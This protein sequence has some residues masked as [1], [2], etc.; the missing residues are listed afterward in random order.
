MIQF[1]WNIRS[2]CHTV[3]VETT[4][5]CTCIKLVLFYDLIVYIIILFSHD[6]KR[7]EN[8]LFFMKIGLKFQTT[9]EKPRVNTWYVVAMEP[10]PHHVH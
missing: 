9:K 3:L 6:W 7:K 8:R 1:Y 5:L 10:K 4:Y 2:D